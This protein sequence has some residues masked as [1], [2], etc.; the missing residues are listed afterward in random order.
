VNKSLKFILLGIFSLFVVVMLTG[1]IM[2]Y[3][4]YNQYVYEKEY[5]AKLEE[6]QKEVDE[7]ISN[8]STI[9]TEYI[10]AY[11]KDKATW[12][13]IMDSYSTAALFSETEEERKMYEELSKS[14]LMPYE[15]FKAQNVSWQ[16]NAYL[17][18]R[19]IELA[20]SI[21]SKMQAFENPSEKNRK[22]LENISKIKNLAFELHAYSTVDF[23]LM[24]E[25]FEGAEFKFNQ[26]EN[27]VI[28]AMREIDSKK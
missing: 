2:A 15:L 26:Y 21:K 13:E 7:L 4:F 23:M 3:R 14:N 22:T 6:V 25:T 28:N 17:F 18:D 5:T 12:K 16:Q 1:G 19:N 20:N 24:I 8:S 11:R 9:C 10:T 27:K